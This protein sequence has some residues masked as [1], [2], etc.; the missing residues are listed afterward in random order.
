M[1]AFVLQSA[2]SRAFAS[3][4][5]IS[6]RISILNLDSLD[7]Q[8]VKFAL[9]FDMTGF[10]IE[11]KRCVS[12]RSSF[13]DGIVT[14]FVVDCTSLFPE[15]EKNYPKFQFEP[16]LTRIVGFRTQGIVNRANSPILDGARYRKV[17]LGQ[18]ADS[19]HSCSSPWI[20]ASVCYHLS[21]RT[22]FF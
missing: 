17:S 22:C 11:F 12:F 7:R 20:W 15:N 5:A 6:S 2:P 10:C 4:R 13:Q 16:S 8:S 19:I 9:S 1:S 18:A 14:A 21:P 3:N